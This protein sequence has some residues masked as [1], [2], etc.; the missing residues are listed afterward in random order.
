MTDPKLYSEDCPIDIERQRGH[1]DRESP[2]VRPDRPWYKFYPADIPKTLNFEM[3]EK[4]NGL[5]CILKA[6]AD[7]FFP[8]NVALN[9]YQRE[10][11][12]TYR[13]VDYYSMKMASALE[14]IGVKKGDPVA[15]MSKSCP[16]FVFAMW[17]CIKLGAILVPINPLLKKW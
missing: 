5:Y 15:L 2:W 13:E 7:K 17:A 11:K 8:N 10:L 3:L 4:Y 9:F 6:S 12:Y 16:E 1:F 14:K